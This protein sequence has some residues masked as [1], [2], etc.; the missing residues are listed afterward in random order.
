[1]LRIMGGATAGG[2]LGLSLPG[3]A[4]AA[5]KDQRPN[6]VCILS[7]DHRWDHLGATGHP[8]LRTPNLD[9]LAS[10][11]ILFENSFVTTSLCSPSR[12]SFLTGTYAHTHGVKNNITPW[13]GKH[14]TFLESLKGAGYDTAFIGKW[15]MPGKGLPDLGFLD[16]FVSF[17][18]KAGQGKYFNC[19]LI[20]NGVETPSRKIH[21]TE[22]LTDRAIEFM[23]RQRESPFCLYLSHKAIHNAYL[24]PK[25]IDGIYDDEKLSMPEDM[26]IWT[27]MTQGHIYDGHMGLLPAHYRNYCECI[28]DMDR[29]IGRVLDKIDKMGIADNTIVVYTSDNG[30]LW[31]EHR[32]INKYWFYEESIRIPFIVRCPWLIDDPGTRRTQMTLNI[33]L[34]PTLLDIC[35]VPAPGDME[36]ASLVSIIKNPSEFGREAWLYEYFKNYPY[37][38]PTTFGVRTRTHKYVEFEGRRKPELYNLSVDPKE[39]VN[40]V[41]TTEGEALSRELK[42]MLEALKGSNIK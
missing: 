41:G 40:L 5:P 19:P 34:A 1:M 33:D 2:I 36:G 38:I 18:V 24:A 32:K 11:G 20:V 30:L 29:Q 12:A 22:E 4:P 10:E 21:I 39:K 8:F 13:T 25:D 16:E 7:D 35:S 6:I 15:H 28:T 17:T 3:I 23:E 31:G 42:A 27:A 9:R 26:D 37:N 14:P